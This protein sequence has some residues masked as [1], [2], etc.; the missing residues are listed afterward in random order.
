VKAPKNRLLTAEDLGKLAKQLAEA[1]NPLEA[2]RL[3][4][5]LI[6]GFYGQWSPKGRKK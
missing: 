2:K 1:Q 6:R 5:K 4:R 3:E